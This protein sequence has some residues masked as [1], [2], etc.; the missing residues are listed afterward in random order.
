[1]DAHG[2]EAEVIMSASVSGVAETTAW[3]RRH[4]SDAVVA[5]GGEAE[6]IMSASVSGVAET[7]A[8]SRRHWSDAV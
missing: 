2:G 5:H 4:W 8:W 3:S 1:M 6:V 7:T